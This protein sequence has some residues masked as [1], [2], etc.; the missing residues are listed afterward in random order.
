[1]NTIPE[2][3]LTTHL[4]SP[5][6]VMLCRAAE[7]FFAVY[8]LR[9]LA[10]VIRHAQWDTFALPSDDDEFASLL[11]EIRLHGL[12]PALTCLLEHLLRVVAGRGDPKVARA[13]LSAIFEAKTSHGAPE[14]LSDEAAAK[15]GCRV[16]LDSYQKAAAAITAALHVE[17]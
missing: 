2:P 14:D 10:L 12:G 11:A 3:T 9:S 17:G 7:P 13:A 15:A 1:M 6:H 16:F 4:A 5:E 8:G